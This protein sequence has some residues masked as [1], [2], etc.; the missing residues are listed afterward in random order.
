MAAKLPLVTRKDIRDNYDGKLPDLKARF[1]DLLGEE[2]EFTTDFQELFGLINQDESYQK[3]SMGTIAYNACES[4]ADQIKYITD[5]D[6]AELFKEHMNQVVS[7]KQVKVLVEDMP[8]GYT[9]C[10]V[11]DGVLQLIYKTGN[12]GTNT[13]YIASELQKV[14]DES[15]HAT[16]KGELPLAAKIGFQTEFL[17]KK[18]KLE[19]DIAEELNDEKVTLVADPAAIWQLAV[20]EFDKLKKR[21]Q[22]EIDLESISRNMGAAIYAYFDGFLGQIKYQFKQDELVVEGFLELCSKKEIHFKLVPKGGLTRSYNDAIFEDDC[23]VI[24]ATPQTWYT[25]SSYACDDIMKLL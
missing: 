4:L 21:E 11:T 24:R 3:D 6:G 13:S 18:E 5:K 20:E 10:R 7:K 23:Y 12:Y 17:D 2:Y 25:N 22:S 8:S 14:L 16:N 9:L 15:F 19:A 1:K